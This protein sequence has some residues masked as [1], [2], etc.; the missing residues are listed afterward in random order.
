MRAAVLL[1]WFALAAAALGWQL[2]VPGRGGPIAAFAMVAP[3]LLP[4]PG[5]WHARRYTYRWA[6]ITLVPAMAWSLT[7]LVANPGARLAAGMTAALAFVALAV[8]VAALRVPA[9]AD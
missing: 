2:S 9:T 5:L 4:L 7:E 1:A 8:L 6:A 3:L